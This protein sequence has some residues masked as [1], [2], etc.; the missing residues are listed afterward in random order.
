MA[1]YFDPGIK[2]VN[3]SFGYLSN[4][5]PALSIHRESNIISYSSGGGRTVC[6]LSRHSKNIYRDIMF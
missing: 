4:N 3:L 5:V 6:C 2:S 1:K